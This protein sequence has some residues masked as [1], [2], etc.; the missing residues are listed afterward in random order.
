MWKGES[1][2]TPTEATQLVY[3][4]RAALFGLQ[5]QFML[6]KRALVDP[7]QTESLERGYQ[8]IL[9]TPAF[10]ALWTRSRGTYA[11][12]FVAYVE[13]LL[14]D[15]PLGPSLDFAAQIRESVA[16]MKAPGVVG[17]Q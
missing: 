3:L 6:K 17:E 1:E 10:R 15:A 13:T 14:G 2:F 12:D 7:V 9:G 11:P 5:D 4:L 16:E 8:N